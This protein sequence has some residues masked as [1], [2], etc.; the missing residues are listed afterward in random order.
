LL[1]DIIILSILAVLSGAESWDSI[2]LYDRENIDFLRQILR[3]PGGIPSHDAINR[4][5]GMINSR[6]FEQSFARWAADL[7]QSGKLDRVI[8][9]DGKTV[10]GSKE[11]FHAKSPIHL[12]HAWSVENEIY[13]GQRKVSNKGN[14]ITALPELLDMIEVGGAVVTI[15]A[16]GTQTAIAKKIIE[17]GGDYILAVKGNQGGVGWGEGRG[18]GNLFASSSHE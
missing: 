13:L 16:M 4:V 1:L 14:E 7:K 17:C 11:T 5:M 6:R 8:A 18:F 10:R 3:L 2:E 15:D 12:V 9:L